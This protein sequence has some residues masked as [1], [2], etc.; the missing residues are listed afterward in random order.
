MCVFVEK[1]VELRKELN[2]EFGL[3]ET[4]RAGVPDEAKVESKAYTATKANGGLDEEQVLPSLM[5][6]DNA[7]VKSGP[8]NGTMALP[9]PEQEKA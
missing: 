9:S 8:M 1:H 6:H 2:T 7:I 3:E 5:S 4:Y